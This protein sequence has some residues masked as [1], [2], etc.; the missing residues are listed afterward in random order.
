MN[1]VPI[2]AAGVPRKLVE[3]LPQLTVRGEHAVPHVHERVGAD[4]AQVLE[5]LGEVLLR[6]LHRLH[7]CDRESA[8]P[9]LHPEVP[10]VLLAVG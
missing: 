10:E 5:V 9:T 7:R 4:R 1:A 6:L 3:R 8:P 2:T